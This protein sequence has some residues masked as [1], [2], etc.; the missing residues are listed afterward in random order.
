MPI[1]IVCSSCHQK[2]KAPEAAA[3]RTLRCP[4]CDLFVSIPIPFI[5]DDHSEGVSSVPTEFHRSQTTEIG[6]P[7]EVG[8]DLLRLHNNKRLRQSSK[9]ESIL[10]QKLILWAMNGVTGLLVLA[11]VCL[12]VVGWPKFIPASPAQTEEPNRVAVV[13][14]LPSLAEQ[15]KDPVIRVPAAPI[16]QPRTV[17]PLVQDT[18][19]EMANWLLSRRAHLA[20]HVYDSHT[21][22]YVE[23]KTLITSQSQVPQQP[24]RIHIVALHRQQVTFSDVERVSQLPFL[25]S[26]VFDNTNVTDQC[27]KVLAKNA[28]KLWRVSLQFTPI[29]DVGI[30]ALKELPSLREILIVRTRVTPQGVARF[31][32]ALPN[33]HVVGP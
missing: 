29:T 26:V 20:V 11:A 32:A 33:C 8:V 17:T 27:M 10:S 25:E 9:K 22:T 2:L 4:K 30:D 15:R 19:R 21:Q 6:S 23:Y 28:R 31:K 24:F 5:N 12:L 1:S 14:P 18:E 7:Q 13:R 16:N 3:G